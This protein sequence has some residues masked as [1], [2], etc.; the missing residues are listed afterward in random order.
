LHEYKVLLDMHV[1]P[2]Q[3]LTSGQSVSV[4]LGTSL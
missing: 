4:K 3:L 1:F 2:A